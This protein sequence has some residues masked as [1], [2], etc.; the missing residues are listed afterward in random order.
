MAQKFN[1]WVSLPNQELLAQN[2]PY[3]MDMLM[4]A[5]AAPIEQMAAQAEP[6]PPKDM[7]VP[8]KQQA[9]PVARNDMKNGETQSVTTKTKLTSPD[10][11]EAANEAR[12]R[13]QKMQEDRFSEEQ[14]GINQ[15]NQDLNKY[16]N[17]SQGPDFRGI[18]ALVDRF[19]D[20]STYKLATDFKP[21]SSEDKRAKLMGMK[22]KLQSMKQGLSKSQYDALKEQLDS[23]N[24][25]MNAVTSENKLMMS[26]GQRDKSQERLARRDDDKDLMEF[27]KRVQPLQKVDNTV[28]GVENVLGFNLNEYDDSTGTVRGEKV[29]APGV[30]LPMLGRI[31][32]ATPEGRQFKAALARLM[33]TV[34][35]ERSGAA[36]TESE[37]QR[38]LSEFANGRYK[39]NSEADL[40]STLK[41]YQN[42]LAQD[43][44]DVMSGF[45]PEIVSRYYDKKGLAHNYKRPDVVKEKIAPATGLS[46]EKQKRLE[47][48]RA[49]AGH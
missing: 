31:N 2:D 45:R 23:Y 14:A 46:P 19:G 44:S 18:A 22:E 5:S 34:L 48:L 10:V 43:K 49:K 24:S 33:N 6:L 37:E 13:L 39:F 20:G 12:D 4:N 32:Q 17:E 38:L 7:V 36:V 29:D 28:G 35:K 16:A 25:Q 11:V 42:L 21:E 40:L 27:Q 9:L 26:L 30:N 8:P 41:T 47:E 3:S 15:Y 1:P